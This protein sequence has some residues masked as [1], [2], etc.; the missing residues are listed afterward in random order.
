MGEGTGVS[1]PPALA[2]ALSGVTQSQLRYWRSRS[3]GKEP[4]LEPEA[5]RGRFV[6]YSFR[7]LL[8][9]RTFGALRADV[10][11]QMI[12][13]AVA[14]LRLFDDVEHLS[15]YHLVAAGKTI[16]WVGDDQ[17]VDLVKVPGQQLLIHMRDVLAE[18]ESRNHQLVVPL[19]RPKQGV[20][21]NPEIIAGYPAIE[22]TRIPYDTI[23]ELAAEGLDTARIKYFYPAVT[24]A[25]IKG[26]VSFERYVTD[27][28]QVAS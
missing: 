7:D 14:N 10:T 4:L 6:R 28:N 20:S 9:L 5:R 23:A 8:A 15:N 16:V 22:G 21:I 18:F 13:K 11:L 26:A 2:A 12:R 1:Y 24:S 19:L 17:T 27:Y 25:G 3:N